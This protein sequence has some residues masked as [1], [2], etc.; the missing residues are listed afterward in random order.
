[1]VDEYILSF[2]QRV[3][4]IRV[5]GLSRKSGIACSL[6]RFEPCEVLAFAISKKQVNYLGHIQAPNKEEKSNMFNHW[7]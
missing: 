1:M 6:H 3:F 7:S 5:H 2:S 4:S